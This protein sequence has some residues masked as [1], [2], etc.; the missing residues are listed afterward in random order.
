MLNS[1]LRSHIDTLFFTVSLFM[2]G[3]HKRSDWQDFKILQKTC[4][5]ETHKEMKRMEQVYRLWSFNHTL[6]DCLHYSQP[7]LG[8]PRALSAC[9]PWLL[10]LLSPSIPGHLSLQ[11]PCPLASSLFPHLS[12]S[13]WSPTLP[14]LTNA[15]QPLASHGSPLSLLSFLLWP[16]I[17]SG[18]LKIHSQSPLF[19]LKGK[20]LSFSWSACL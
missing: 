6:W 13:S 1:V 2:W 11:S 18:I 9:N 14:L 10:L 7:G 17:P 4:V 15:S 16:F 12:A 3:V 5:E 19:L 20:L 8:S